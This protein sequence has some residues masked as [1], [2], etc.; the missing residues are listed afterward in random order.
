MKK[1]LGNIGK[2][3]TLER[4]GRELTRLKKQTRGLKTLKWHQPKRKK[5]EGDAGDG[6]EQTPKS[7][8]ATVEVPRKN[9]E[10]IMQS[11][12][13]LH[14][15]LPKAGKIKKWGKLVAKGFEKPKNSAF[16]WDMHTKYEKELKSDAEAADDDADGSKH[17][18]NTEKLRKKAEKKKKKKIQK[19]AK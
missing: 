1:T 14:V 5:D 18:A 11:V 2:R 9:S 19:E 6:T 4:N 7:D 12:G 16:W 15:T 8:S 17:W 10:F 3:P 13:R